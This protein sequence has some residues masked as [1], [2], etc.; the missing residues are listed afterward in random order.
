MTTR[1]FTL[2][3]KRETGREEDMVTLS[4]KELLPD[5]GGAIVI[6][7]HAGI[8]VTVLTDEA[9]TERGV[10]KD[11]IT[12]AGLDVS[13]LAYCRFAGGITMFYPRALSLC[14]AE[15]ET[16]TEAA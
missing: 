13:G 8:E 12:C 14:I 15:A 2:N 1:I 16:E 10:A 4:L 7:N 5:D 3:T 9:V 6:Q 11:H